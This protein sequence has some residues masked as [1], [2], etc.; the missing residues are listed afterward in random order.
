M[1]RI[2]FL[3]SGMNMPDFLT[4]VESDLSEYYSDRLR[5]LWVNYVRISKR[6]GEYQLQLVLFPDGVDNPY[7]IVTGEVITNPSTE[8]VM[9]LIDGE[10]G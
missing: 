3:S 9:G 2:N 8:Y 1:E 5:R 4:K 7:R 6:R 10:L